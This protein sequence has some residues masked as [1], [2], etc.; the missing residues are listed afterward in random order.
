MTTPIVPART[1]HNGEL[2]FLSY[3]PLQNVNQKTKVHAECYENAGY[4]EIHIVVPTYTYTVGYTYFILSGDNLLGYTAFTVTNV[5]DAN[6]YTTDIPYTGDLFYADFFAISAED[7][8]V[9][10]QCTNVSGNED[11]A[12]LDTTS[13]GNET[14][15]DIDEKVIKLDMTLFVDDNLT[16]ANLLGYE[17]LPK[18]IRPIHSF[19]PHAFVLIRTYANKQ[20]KITTAYDAVTWKTLNRT[21]QA[22]KTSFAT[23]ILSGEAKDSY[24]LTEN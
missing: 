4:L 21:H 18:Q 22:G 9:T 24:I 12:T 13:I 16:I 2:T 14:I 1:R 15:K 11:L 19:N 17:T 5:P 7:T 8:I 20:L 23:W 6:K 3:Y 10:G